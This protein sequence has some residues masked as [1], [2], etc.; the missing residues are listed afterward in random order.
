MS[1]GTCLVLGA[2]GFIGSHLVDKLARRGFKVVAFDRFGT[3][4]QFLPSSEVKIVQGDASSMQDIELA[5][6]GVDYLIHSFSATT[7]A[8]ADHDPYT[9]ISANLINSVRIFEECVSAKLKK[10]VFISSGGVIYGALSEHRKAKETDQALPVSPYGIS[11]L[12]IERYLGY[13]NRK[14]GIDH[15]TYRL[16]NP[17]GPRQ[18]TKNNQGVVPA[19]I[20]QILAN[21]EITVVGDGTSSR[22]YIYIEDAAEM[23]V[24]SFAKENMQ[25][26]YN[27]GSGIQTK[28]KDLVNEIQSVTGKKAR[29]KNIEAPETFL[30]KSQLDVSLLT[31]EFGLSSKTSFRDGIRKTIAEYTQD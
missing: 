3:P 11:K 27:L 20:G 25:D 12:A 6:V 9:D 10:I 1:K 23:I 29:I 18:V 17:Y 24:D 28:L 15:I 16:S 2:N 4:A 14:Y 7:P 30:Q 8:S 31:N 5:M 21:E 19:F 26:I 22:D 13:F